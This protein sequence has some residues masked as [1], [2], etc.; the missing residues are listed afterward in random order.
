MVA[1]P[2]VDCTAPECTDT[3]LLWTRLGGR[4]F[5]TR[6]PATPTMT[7]STSPTR[8]SATGRWTPSDVPGFISASALAVDIARG[9][10]HVPAHGLLLAPDPVR[11]AGHGPLR[12]DARRLDPRAEDGGSA[13]GAGRRRLRAGGPFRSLGGRSDEHPLCRDLPRAHL[14]HGP[15][16]NHSGL[17][18]RRDAL[19]GEAARLRRGL[20]KSQLDGRAL[21]R[22]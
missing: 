10:G 17:H 3:G 4:P 8:W 16:R 5:S 2:R 7:V 20:E 14:R 9:S 13:R 1:A 19:R 22:G 18:L 21:G 11:Q 15:L 6:R 12:P